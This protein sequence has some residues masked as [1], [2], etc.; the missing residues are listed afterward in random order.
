MSKIAISI[1]CDTVN[2]AQE[3]LAKLNQTAETPK[4]AP[5]AKV[6]T[7]APQPEVE[8]ESEEMDFDISSNDAAGGDDE[9]MD[10]EEKP[11]AKTKAPKLTEKDVNAAAIKHA[12][13]NGRD[14]T[15]ALLSKKFKVKSILELKPD[16][17]ADAV[18]ALA[19]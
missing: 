9:E 12:K 2:E 17:Y 19:V 7:S 4:T 8:D 14:K 11:K 13:A 15:L 3:I 16:Q 10:F 5:K 18:A 6:K 1:Q